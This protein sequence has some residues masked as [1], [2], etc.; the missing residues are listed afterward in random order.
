MHF[1]AGGPEWNRTTTYGFG[2][3]RILHQGPRQDI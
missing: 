2:G 1:E 3:Q